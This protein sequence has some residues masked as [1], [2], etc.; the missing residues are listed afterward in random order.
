MLLSDRLHGQ[1][2]EGGLSQITSVQKGP[3]GHAGIQ[4]G[5]HT[6]D[7]SW[8]P[9]RTWACARGTPEKDEETGAQHTGLLLQPLCFCTSLPS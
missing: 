1:D 2:E 5:P 7:G 9:W 8:L 3:S 4:Q 6:G